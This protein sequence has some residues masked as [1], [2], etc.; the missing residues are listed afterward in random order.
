MDE[1]PILWGG[2]DSSAAGLE[3][4]GGWAGWRAAHWEESCLASCMCHL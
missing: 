2:Q 4:A 3:R 1:S